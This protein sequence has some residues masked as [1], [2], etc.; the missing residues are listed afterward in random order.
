MPRE[1][2]LKRIV[3]DFEI[4]RLFVSNTSE[5]GGGKINV[6][7][8]VDCTGEGQNDNCQITG[9]NVD[10]V[11]FWPS[12]DFSCK[13]GYEVRYVV[14]SMDEC[15]VQPKELDGTE[16]E[17]TISG[18]Q[19]ASKEASGEFTWKR[20]SM[21]EQKQWVDGERWT[22]VTGDEDEYIKKQIAGGGLYSLDESRNQAMTDDLQPTLKLL[23]S[24]LRP[25]VE[26][27][28]V[29]SEFM[30]SRSGELVDSERGRERGVGVDDEG[31]RREATT[32]E[33]RGESRRI[34][35]RQGEKVRQTSKEELVEWAGNTSGNTY[36][37]HDGKIVT[38]EMI[39]RLE[40]CV[41]IR[42]V[43]RLPGGG[44]KK[45]VVPKNKGGGDLSAT[46]ESSSSMLS[47][48]RS[49]WATKMSEVFGDGTAEQV[50]SIASTEPGGWTEAWARKIMEVG[51]EEKKKS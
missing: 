25:I 13:K 49:S 47:S 8:Y 16:L 30:R 20:N 21:F 39:D 23:E 15:A 14:D 11:S 43:N 17:T 42:L 36:A 22:A 38:A 41:T 28:H 46:E 18:V 48:E 40:D 35:V 9:E 26:D 7:G 10:V 1:R 27:G 33:R 44:R 2:I 32:V 24:R 5:F 45:K 19:I 37:V 51:E 34:Y 6:E 3:D 4:A 50:K 31:R 29:S 12:R